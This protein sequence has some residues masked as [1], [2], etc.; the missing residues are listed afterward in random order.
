MSRVRVDLTVEI[1]LEAWKAVA[2]C[3]SQAEAR[4][5]LKG[6]CADVISAQLRNYYWFPA[7]VHVNI[8]NRPSRF[9]Q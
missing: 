4:R 1:D 5:D 3:S 8:P 6:L 9:R 2:G 7:T